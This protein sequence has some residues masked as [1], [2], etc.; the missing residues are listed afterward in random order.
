MNINSKERENT[1]NSTLTR[2]RTRSQ[3]TS[4]AL[5]HLFGCD[6]KHLWKKWNIIVTFQSGQLTEQPKTLDDLGCFDLKMFR[7]CSI[8]IEIITGSDY[9]CDLY[10]KKNRLI[11]RLFILSWYNVFLF[12]SE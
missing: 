5:K 2:R 3:K 1:S 6:F 9:H 4:L 11:S 8:R 10:P 12:D 7:N